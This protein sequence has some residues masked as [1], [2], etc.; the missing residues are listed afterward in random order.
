MAT[1]HNLAYVALADAFR[2]PVPGRLAALRDAVG[3]LP[4]SEIKNA[5][6]AFIRDVEPMTLGAWEEL[7]TRTLD[8]DPPAAP[9][10]GYQMWGDSY[11]RGAF[12]V[13]M[14]R[15]LADAGVDKDGELPDH[16]GAC[17]RY[18]AATSEP[19]PELVQVLGPAVDRM[20]KALSGQPDS[21][22]I[23]LLQAART[24]GLALALQG[25]KKEAA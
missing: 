7:H 9:Y 16:L 18:L 23:A 17:L 3:T 20:L 13:K 2:Y 11:Q 8:L 4:A 22:Y 12:M 6:A 19:L 10:L 5:L 14:N 24:V 21:P 15:V 25:A 1:A